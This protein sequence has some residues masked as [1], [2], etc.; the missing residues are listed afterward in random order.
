MGVS[1]VLAE[2]IGLYMAIIGILFL[3]NRRGVVEMIRHFQQS[4]SA[5]MLSGFIALILGLI[6]IVFHNI[7]IFGWPLIITLIGYLSII[8]GMVRITYPNAFVKISD[9]LMQNPVAYYITTVVI[10]LLGGFLL[11][12]A[13]LF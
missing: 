5:I 10:L 7:W 12:N 6:I 3:L 13:F 9:K 11:Y 8:K 4:P 2:I 1:V